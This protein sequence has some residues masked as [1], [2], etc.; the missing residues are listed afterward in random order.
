MTGTEASAA[1]AGVDDRPGMEPEPRLLGMTLAQ[2]AGVM[3]GLGEMH[4]L[5]VVL[6]N[7]GVDPAIHAR[8]S[9][10]WAELLADE[11]DRDATPLNDGFATRLADAQDRLG[12]R[13]T[14]LA[15]DLGA[16][17]DFVRIWSAHA[18]PPRFLADLG[19]R[20][21]DV[22]RLQREWAQRLEIEP[23]LQREAHAL[24]GSEPGPMP[25]LTIGPSPLSRP[26]PVRAFA[27]LEPPADF[28][29]DEEEREG[30][31][32][33]DPGQVAAAAPE[34]EPASPPLFAPLD[35]LMEEPEP[36]PPAAPPVADASAPVALPTASASTPPRGAVVPPA[37][38]PPAA[39]PLAVVPAAVVPPAATPPGPPPA[40]PVSVPPTGVAPGAAPAPTIEEPAPATFGVGPRSVPRTGADLKR[41]V[42]SLGPIGP[43]MPFVATPPSQR[44]PATDASSATAHPFR[45]ATPPGG[46]AAPGGGPPRGATPP[47]G[48]AA[49]ASGASPGGVP[50]LTLLQYASLCA[51]LEVSPTT[52]E[53]TFIRYGLQHASDRRAVDVAWKE[54]LQ[55][56]ATARHEWQRAYQAY[57]A[58]L[59]AR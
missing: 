6:A 55:R 13:I 40:P 25:A 26:P 28:E 29:E 15:D 11:L 9:S 54:R 34:D 21:T 24:L 22:I 5:D 27:D 38:T 17:L 32:D 4:P 2:Y 30:E 50:S 51:E 10:A 14:P 59:R 12:R 41:T 39:V 42:M 23:R 33:D 58:S 43:A 31:D 1:A 36:A 57:R 44:A 52:S 18:E 35:A 37:M 20:G 56:D 45:S 19:L 16:W 47:A 48:V 8:A 7:E 3:T 53:Q 49:P 46:V